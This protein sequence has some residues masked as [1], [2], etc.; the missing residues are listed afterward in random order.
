MT[1]QTMKWLADVTGG[2]LHGADVVFT[3]VST[4]TRQLASGQLFVALSGPNFDGHRFL[5]DA[6]ETGA[7]GALVERLR[8]DCDLPQVV[9]RNT[10]QALGCMARAWRQN[11]DLPLIGVT[12]SNGK[13]TVKEMAASILRQ[14]GPVL[15]TRGNLNN[16]IG[17]PLTLLEIEQ[18]HRAAVIELGANHAGEIDYLAR[19]ALPTIGIVNNAGPAHLEGFGSLEGVARAKGEL[20]T[21][22]GPAG[23]AVINADD[24]FAEL[25]RGLSGRRQQLRF[26][27]KA[28]AEFTASDLSTETHK[29]GVATRF[30]LRSVAGERTIQI[31]LGGRHNVAN[32]LAAAAVAWAAGASL[33]D[34]EAGLA[35]AETVTGRLQMRTAP[36]GAIIIDDSYN[37]NPGSLGAAL[38]VQQDLDREAWLVLGDMGELGQATAELHAAAGSDARAAGVSRLFACGQHSRHAVDAFG[39]GAAWFERPDQ[40]CGAVLAESHPDLS[41]LVKASRSMRFE[42]VVEALLSGSV[43]PPLQANGG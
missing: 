4:D 42:R 7:A 3:S 17:V 41:I 8:E 12:G 19:L 32:A 31:P 22:L 35:V 24:P 40:L 1:P 29:Q 23:V 27:L 11:F 25:W 9:V 2:D 20:F 37:A 26:G 33:D 10:R 39:E 16:D 5:Q 13:T 21:A 14:M 36:G 28:E 43:E 34:I 18:R 30:T 15:A 38:A 6:S